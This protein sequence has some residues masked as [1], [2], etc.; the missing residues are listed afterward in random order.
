[1][2]ESSQRCSRSEASAASAKPPLTASHQAVGSNPDSESPP[3]G[4]SYDSHNNDDDGED[5]PFDLDFILTVSF[6]GALVKSVNSQ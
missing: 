6:L 5:D 4:A 3:D 2:Y 1:M